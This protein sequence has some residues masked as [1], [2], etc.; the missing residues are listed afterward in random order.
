MADAD[1]VVDRLDVDLVATGHFKGCA[2][3]LL[4]GE[5]AL[6]DQS[7]LAGAT[8]FAVGASVVHGDGHHTTRARTGYPTGISHDRP[9]VRTERVRSRPLR[10]RDPSQRRRGGRCRRTCVYTV[11]RCSNASKLPTSAKTST[12]LT[13]AD[14]GPCRAHATISSTTSVGPATVASTDPSRRFR[15][16]P[17]RPSRRACSTMAHR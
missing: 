12:A 1:A 4:Q 2:P 13:E 6:L 11:C 17:H 3:R 7:H 10:R 5:P 15:T 14:L 16:Q 9:D 8:P